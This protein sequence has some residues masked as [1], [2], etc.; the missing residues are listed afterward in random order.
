MGWGGG[1][2]REKRGGKDGREL[3]MEEESVGKFPK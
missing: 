2:V 1:L 3:W